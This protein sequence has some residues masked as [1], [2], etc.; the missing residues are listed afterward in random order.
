MQPLTLPRTGSSPTDAVADPTRD[1]SAARDP[2]TDLDGGDS[3]CML[4][5]ETQPWMRSL[6]GDKSKRRTG[7]IGRKEG[8]PV[9]PTARRGIVCRSVDVSFSQ[10]KGKRRGK[11]CKSNGVQRLTA[12]SVLA[13]KYI[14]IRINIIF[15][16]HLGL[17]SPERTTA[18]RKA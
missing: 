16:F 17:G 4:P 9:S 2:V 8:E 10:Y 11:A 3:D 18:A 7:A 5:F 15:V 12:L 6:S 13:I 14:C 1:R